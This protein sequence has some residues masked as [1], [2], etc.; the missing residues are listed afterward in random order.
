[1]LIP[2]E[3]PGLSVLGISFSSVIELI[4]NFLPTGDT[5]F[6]LIP[7]ELSSKI[8]QSD[9]LTYNPEI[10]LV[11]VCTYSLAVFS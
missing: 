11:P 3:N 1:M 9:F 10:H 5:L 4:S 2:N 6:L 7:I 8:S